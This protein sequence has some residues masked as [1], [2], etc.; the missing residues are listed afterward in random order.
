M[1]NAILKLEVKFRLC[2]SVDFDPFTDLSAEYYLVDHDQGEELPPAFEIDSI[3]YEKIA[4]SP[5]ELEKWSDEEALLHG[6]FGR[7]EQILVSQDWKIL[8]KLSLVPDCDL[9][10]VDIVFHPTPGTAIESSF[11]YDIETQTIV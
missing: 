8:C 11:S 10:L 1:K 6:I 9:R 2:K 4:E 3:E 5:P 7:T